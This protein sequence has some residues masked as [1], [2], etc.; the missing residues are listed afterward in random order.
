MAGNR[1]KLAGKSRRARWFGPTSFGASL[2]TACGS[3][4]VCDAGRA[5]SPRKP[6][7]VLAARSQPAPGRERAAWRLGIAPCRG[8]GAGQSA[9]G[10]LTHRG[11]SS[12]NPHKWGCGARLTRATL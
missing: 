6:A 10:N 2:R 11:I 5:M 7:R 1:I 8:G 9:R 3:T 4:A 12:A